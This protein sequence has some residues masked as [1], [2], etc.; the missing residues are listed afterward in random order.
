[1]PVDKLEKCSTL[2]NKFL[3]MNRCTLKEMQSLIGVLN[4]ACSVIQPGRAF[5]RRMINL[6]MKVSEI[7]K[8]LYISEMTKE[9]MRM[10]LKFLNNFNGKLMFLNET[11][12]SS[13]TLELHTDA[14]QSKGYGGIYKTKWFYGAFPDDWKNTNIMTLEF[15][16]IIL[17]LEMWGSLWRNHSILFFTD[18][19]ALVAVINKQT[20]QDNHVMKMVRCMVLKCLQNSILFKAKHIP[21]KKNVFADYLSRLQVEQFRQLA[22]WAQVDPCL[23]PEKF[24]P[25]NFWSTL[26]Y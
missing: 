3:N 23:V 2:L 8:H 14:A 12:M 24:M 1:M 19:E 21:G 25:Q 5:L 17:A 22:P 10:W 9:D 13:T 26:Q 11:F 6:T 15:Y 7:Q 16:T 20:S 18:N 4:F